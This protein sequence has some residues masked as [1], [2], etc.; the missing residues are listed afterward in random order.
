M[1]GQARER[2]ANYSHPG[3]Y[4]HDLIATAQV[5]NSAEDLN[6]LEPHLGKGA[7]VLADNAR[8]PSARLASFQLPFNCCKTYG[9]SGGFSFGGISNLCQR[10]AKGPGNCR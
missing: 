7:R 8:Y 3:P 5:E 1:L 4:P 9:L 2:G 10:V 6:A